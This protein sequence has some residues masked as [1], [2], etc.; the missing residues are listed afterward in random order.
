LQ[1]KEIVGENLTTAILA[2]SLAQDLLCLPFWQKTRD[3]CRFGSHISLAV[4]ILSA[5]YIGWYNPPKEG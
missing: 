3:F 5:D 2:D 4:A 1:E